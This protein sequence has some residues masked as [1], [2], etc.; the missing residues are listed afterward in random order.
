M[1]TKITTAFETRFGRPPT[2][3]V[4]APGRV[5]LLGEH[6]DYNDGFVF[7]MAVDRAAWVAATPSGSPET[8]IAALDLDA[9][10]RFW[11]EALPEPQRD[12]ADYPRGVAWALQ[13][14][15]FDLNGMAAVVSSDVP[16]GAGLSSSAAIEVAFAYAWQQISGFELDRR[17][18]ALA[19]QRAE[20]RYVGVNCGIMDQ[21]TSALGI[22]GHALMLDCRSLAAEPMPL[23]AGVAVVV[24]DS[25]VRR[26]LATSEYNVRRAQCEQAVAIFS[27]H[28][29]GIR[30]LR[31]VSPAD[32]E[33]LRGHLP[34]VVYRRARHVVSDIARVQEAAGALRRN[35]VVAFGILMKDCH[36]SLRDDYEVSSPELDRLSEAAWEVPGC[37]GARL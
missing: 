15:G 33:R 4:R 37:Y 17:G 21:M 22:A 28:L 23:P 11:L 12:W 18:L 8:T 34:E 36:V 5:N 31:D 14:S 20:N 3:V 9:E 6:T 13:D 35:D 26:E 19:C 30:A 1:L 29:P 25:G 27:E 10:A 2:L 32:L 7:P 24:A 16:M